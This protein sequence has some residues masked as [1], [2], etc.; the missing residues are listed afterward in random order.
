MAETKQSEILV[1]GSG[2]RLGGAVVKV[3]AA[4]GIEVSGLDRRAL[5]LGE[6]GSIRAVLDGLEFRRVLICGAMTAV[7]ACEDD[8]DLA[9]RINSEAPG[10][11]ARACADRGVPVTFISTDFVF[12]GRKDGPYDEEDEPNPLGVYGA[13]KLA[14][15]RNVLAASGE[16]LVVRVSWL[17]GAQ[18]PAFPEWILAQAR[19]KEELALPA[20]KT[21]SPTSCEDLAELLPALL[22]FDGRE[23]ASGIVHLCNRGSCTWQEWGQACLDL[24]RENGESLRCETIGANQLADIAAFKA[25][26]PA[27]SVLDPS[28]FSAL[29]GRIPRPWIEALRDHFFSS[30]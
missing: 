11:I 15:E 30:E 16:N 29:S 2:G 27:N 1:I 20:D 25:R 4:R 3:L 6:P 18:R 13:S 12:D 22:G 28:R 26:R 9:Y 23:S 7:D 24:A 17:Y 19:E 10:A 14:G 21:G 8:P 5:D